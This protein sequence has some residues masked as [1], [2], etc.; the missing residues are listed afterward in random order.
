MAANEAQRANRKRPTKPAQRLDARA[1]SLF[2][3]VD[4]IDY[5]G[6]LLTRVADNL[7]PKYRARSRAA[8]MVRK[9][10]R[11]EDVKERRKGNKLGAGGAQQVVAVG[12]SVARSNRHERS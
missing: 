9:K 2:L 5:G 11:D 8:V 4:C 1:I 3:S 12:R 6:K 7:H 10:S